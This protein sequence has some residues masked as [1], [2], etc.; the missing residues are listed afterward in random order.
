MNKNNKDKMAVMKAIS[1]NDVK[2]KP[3]ATIII[4]TT[5]LIVLAVTLGILLS[6]TVSV[7]MVWTRLQFIQGHAYGA[8]AA[9]DNM[10]ISFPWSA[11]IVLLLSIGLLVISL[12]KR[13]SLYL[14]KI[15]LNYVI[16]FTI[17][18]SILVGVIVSFSN[19]ATDYGNH[20]GW[21]NPGG[22]HRF[23]NRKNQ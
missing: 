19:V 12:W 11:L 23:Q 18:L 5:L 20:R 8:H 2:I 6:S 13:R 7:M 15:K 10:M 14:Y 17:I 3:K 21:D 16:L 9:L 22:Q 4:V 1:S